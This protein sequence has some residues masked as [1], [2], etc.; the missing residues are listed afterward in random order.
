MNKKQIPVGELRLGMY[1][2]EL[3]RPWLGTPFVFQGFPITSADQINEVKKHC[4]SVFIDL[5]R[6]ASGDDPRGPLRGTVVYKEV[7][8]VEKELVVAREVYSAV[9]RSV[10]ASLEAVRR[11]G[12]LDPKPLTSAVGSMTRSIERNPDAMMLLFSIK[13]KGGEEFKRAVDTSIHMTTF[14]RF[15]QFPGERL[16]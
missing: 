11:T 13:Q 2:T 9:E 15:L 3:D 8:P 16:E 7:T 1:V 12:E 10:R 6:D 14:G 4:R 5:D